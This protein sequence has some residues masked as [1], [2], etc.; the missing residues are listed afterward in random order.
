MDDPI[1]IPLVSASELMILK[2]CKIYL[3][4]NLEYGIE[5]FYYFDE[6][7]SDYDCYILL[8]SHNFLIQNISAN[9][10]DQFRL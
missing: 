1:I 6:I 4:P 5:Y 2:Q 7:K 8:N 9:I 3:L 10:L